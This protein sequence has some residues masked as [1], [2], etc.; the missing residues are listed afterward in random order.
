VAHSP[1][2]RSKVR[3]RIACA[4]F[5]AVFASIGATAKDSKASD[6]AANSKKPVGVAATVPNN[7]PI[8]IEAGDGT[9]G[10]DRTDDSGAFLGGPGWVC[11]VPGSTFRNDWGNARSGG[12]KHEGT[13]VFAAMGAPV[14]AP[15]SGT[16]KRY[17]GG[18]AG[19]AF[20]LTG[21]DGVEYFGAHLSTLTKIG[22]VT[23]GEVIASVG[24]SGNARGGSP[25]LHFEI[26]PTK[27]T[28][29]NP[30]ATL[31]AQCAGVATVK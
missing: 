25:H 11:P 20:Y 13:D 10:V 16:V 4:A 7:Q 17:E 29:T 14:Y 27:K 18:K 2:R 22:P 21:T 9:D 28:K 8:P 26:H 1:V 24:D 6:K 23:A 31:A 12:R 15:V 3:L 5:A 30:Y 19:L